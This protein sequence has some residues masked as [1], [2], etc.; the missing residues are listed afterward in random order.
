[1]SPVRLHLLL[2]LLAGSALAALARAD[3]PS[4]VGAAPPGEKD[5]GAEKPADARDAALFEQEVLPVLKAHC[6]KCHGGP[7][8]RGGL[9]LTSRKGLLAGGDLGPAVSLEKPGDSLLLK[10]IHYRDGLEMPPS[11]K[12]P[13]RQIEVLTRW[14]HA[15]APWPRSSEAVLTTPKGPRVTEEDRRYWAFQTVR[16][17]ALPPVKA[18]GWVRNPI[19]A[20]V[21]AKL[22]AK[23]LRPAPP[24][25]RRTLARRLYY[26]LTGLPPTPEQVDA[27][28][29]DQVADAYERLVD[30]L[31]A[32]PDYGEKWGRHWLDLVRY[33]ETDGFEFDRSKP[34]AWRYRDYV[35]NAFNA[36]K[37]YDQFVREQLAGDLLPVVTQET[38]IATGYYRLGQ[39]DSGAADR[40][41]QKYDVLDG[42]LSTTGQVFLGLSVGC[43][44]CHDHKKDPIPQRDYY[45]LLAFF[46]NISGMGGRGSTKRVM[47]PADLPSYEG[48]LKAKQDREIELARQ[49]YQLEQRFAVALA[50]KKG[51]PAGDLPTP[52]L[53]GLTYRFYR[54]TWENLPD[55]DGLLPETEGSI[56]HNY[57]TLAPASRAEAIGLV[58]EGKLK[59][60]QA[61]DYTFD[62]DSTDGAR[63]IVDGK[64]VLD[65]PG[66]GRQQASAKVRL[67]AG[68]LP[69]R[70]EYFNTYGRPRLQLEWSGPGVPRRPLTG[71][72]RPGTVD[73]P[74]WID[75]YGA[76]L[77]GGQEAERYAELV[78]ALEA[79]R[80]A[81]PAAPGIEV[82]CVSEGYAS[83]T[84]VLIRGNPQAKGEQVEAGFPEVLSP[85][86][87]KP[88]AGRLA[89]AGW[90]TDPNNP[91]T[92]RV[93]VNRLWQHHFGRGIVPT[94]NDLG[95]LG[96]APTHPKLLDWLASEFV[97]SGWRTKPLHRLLLTSSAYRMSSQAEPGAL[98]VDPANLLFWRFNMRRLTAEEVRD[99]VLAV[100]GNLN[101]RAG[102][103]GV[104]PRLPREVL[105]TQDRPGRGWVTSPP[106]E[107]ARRSIY[108]HVK[109][110]L[111]L[112][113]LTQFDLADT[114]QSCPAR[115]TTTVPTQALLMLNDEFTNEQARL[116]AQRLTEEA[117]GGLEAQ[118]TR[119]VRLV[120]GR[121]PAADEVNQDVGFVRSLRRGHGL[122]GQE[123]LRFYC[124]LLLNTN[125]F[126]YLD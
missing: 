118:V 63:L 20:F 8:P 53:T 51:V 61:G 89:L 109:R 60:L 52:D 32:S 115:F 28:V 22:E 86:G 57:V 114:D 108:V 42:I 6:F 3:E 110:S 126:I 62:L 123:A 34:F 26:D 80:K 117:P 104:Y 96:E 73:L 23:G 92:A 85:P 1:M 119:A 43:A 5:A 44:R 38:M 76:E 15:G 47:A 37:A 19:D 9:S 56:A 105:A 64:A 16:R 84:H 13:A 27:F 97:G 81:R 59:V 29:N 11:G 116:F 124:L 71:D 94:P 55:F 102:G 40:L 36:D 58:F 79:S 41:Q 88:A 7:K 91:L 122:S 12:L 120:T 99:S 14:V 68:L 82:L 100:C 33:A 103:P 75:K 18:R 72:V 25:D 69:M 90:L 50:A 17:P 67:R 106:E 21:L 125:E 66:K 48:Q 87:R 93:L 77:L 78:Q 31:L 95:R 2:I 65:R 39:W 54:D 113:Q 49:V 98:A 74:A 111:L 101:R 10:A 4:G 45:R 107:A 46:H 70:L 83:P 121:V 24:A 30:R 112:P 35:I